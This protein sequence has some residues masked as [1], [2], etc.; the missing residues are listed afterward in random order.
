MKLPKFDWLSVTRAIGI[1]LG[2]V[3]IFF[4]WLVGNGFLYLTEIP[5]ARYLNPGHIWDL[6]QTWPLMLAPISG[7]IFLAGCIILLFT[8]WGVFVQTLG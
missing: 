4:A 1:V 2:F 5:M 3:S 6:V 7:L 8:R